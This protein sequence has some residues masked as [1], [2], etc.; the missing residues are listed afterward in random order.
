MK[1]L[2]LK[3]RIKKI[4][5]P[6]DKE[7]SKKIF[8][9]ALPVI[10]SNLSRVLMS[11]FDLAM[12]GGLGPEAIAA[13]GM[14]GMVFYGLIS[15][16]FG[17]KTAVQSI[18]SR[19]LGQNKPKESGRSLYNGLLMA[20]LYGLPL[21]YLCW[22]YSPKIVSFYIN[23]PTSTPLAIQYIEVL[24]AGFLFSAY[25]IVF[26]GF[27]TGIEKTK[28]HLVVTLL[29]NLLNIY[30]NA[31]LIYGSAGIIA[32]FE[33]KAPG[34]TFLTFLWDWTTF[35]KLGV[36]G[37]AIGTVISSA[38]MFT[39]YLAYLLFSSIRKKFYMFPAKID[40]FMLKRQIKLALPMGV[41]EFLIAVGW[42]MYFKVFSLIGIIE[43]AT[44]NIIFSIMHASFMPAI[45]VGQ[46][47]ATYVGK[48]LGEKRPN[49][50]ERSIWESIRIAEYIMGTMGV[51]FMLFPHFFLN[52]FTQDAQV[53]EM[54]A[55]GL[56]ILGVLQFVDAV[57]LPLWFSL[58]A[59]GNT[60]FPAVTEVLILWLWSIPLS[61]F[62]GVYMGFGFFGSLIPL[63]VHYLSFALILGWKIKK[64]TW[65]E[66]EI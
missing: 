37:A 53:L 36:K 10:F 35:P 59:A 42:A 13:T 12:V 65:K 39:Q 17:I 2:I 1:F 47:C 6:Q 61:L 5:L 9:L 45:G 7:V 23:H 55:P 11:L 58:T 24:F 14:G 64:G 46:A 56:R 3:S 31:A 51:S 33:D 43:L 41:Q 40:F 16:V 29:S 22:V 54:G 57:G 19:R 20:T 34:L 18:S 48:F 4:F 30:L 38:F 63:V 28:V 15:V 50:A 27:F 60:L 25:S 52:F 8:F 44:I 49:K 62:L 66:I 26:Q 32:F 21:S